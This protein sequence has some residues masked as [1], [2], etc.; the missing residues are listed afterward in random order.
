MSQTT[1][2]AWTLHIW[3]WMSYADWTCCS[4]S[5]PVSSVDCLIRICPS[6]LSQLHSWCK[7]M[8]C[9]AL[10]CTSNVRW[11]RQSRFAHDY[12]LESASY[13]VWRDVNK[14]S[15][16]TASFAFLQTAAMQQ[17]YGQ[18]ECLSLISSWNTPK[19]SRY[20][21]LPELYA[22]ATIDPCCFWVEPCQLLPSL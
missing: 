18:R 10:G 14:Y 5:T 9:H 12:W 11:Q 1:H 3:P 20:E 22:E 8:K 2:L 21:A 19:F 4:W 7:S 16:Y 6:S 15:N 17:G 13:M